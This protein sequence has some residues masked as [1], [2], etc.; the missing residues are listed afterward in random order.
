M[1]LLAKNVLQFEEI[2]MREMSHD[3]IFDNLII[4]TFT[5]PF[6]PRGTEKSQGQTK[7]CNKKQ[8]LK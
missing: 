8:Q 3:R 2:F 4:G 6:F 5:G 1:I 7:G